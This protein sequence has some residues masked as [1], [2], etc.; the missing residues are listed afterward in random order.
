MITVRNLTKRYGDL[1][2]LD[3]VNFQV[4]RGEV[5]VVIGASG[6]G[7]SSMLRCINF[8][9]EFEDGEI[10]IDG[11]TVGY[12]EKN[13]VRKHRSAA[14]IAKL[15]SEVG[16]VF[17]SFNLFPHRTVLDNVALGPLHVAGVDRQQAEAEAR[18]LLA[19]VGLSEKASSYPSKLSGGQQQRV[20]IARALAMRP[21]VM[22]FDEV[23]SALDPELVGEVLST[24]RELAADGM[25]MI[26]VTHEME[27]A[28]D[29]GDRILF[30]DKGI[31]AEEGTP[32]EIFSNPRSERL[33]SF[34][35][36]F[37]QS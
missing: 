26:I 21:K 12:I 17:Q 7:K 33:Q 30:F 5:V 9:E 32:A 10:L 14:D 4:A 3:R 28:R 29:V 25:T 1:L 2:V 36:R 15:R 8:L 16:M 22:L 11:D 37:R 18:Q 35:G 6:S 27:F 31:I 34:L 24:M 20:A 23:T 19:K 13:G